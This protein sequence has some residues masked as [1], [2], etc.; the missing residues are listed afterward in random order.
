MSE[1]ITVLYHFI[2]RIIGNGDFKLRDEGLDGLLIMILVEN[3]KYQLETVEK[4]DD[5]IVYPAQDE[6]Q[7]GGPI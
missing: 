1:S 7:F 4:A 3:V 6:R 2:E 5:K